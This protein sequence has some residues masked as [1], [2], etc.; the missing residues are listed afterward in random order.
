MGYFVDLNVRAK[1][2]QL[3]KENVGVKLCDLGLGN[4]FLVMTAIAQATEGEKSQI[5]GT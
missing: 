1:T 4:D 2:I 5:H 3:L